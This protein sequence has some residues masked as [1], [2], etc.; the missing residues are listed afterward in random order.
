MTKRPD[1][2]TLTGNAKYRG[3]TLIGEYEGL[4]IFANVD[5]NGFSISVKPKSGPKR[6]RVYS[7]IISPYGFS[8]RFAQGKA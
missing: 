7:S 4:V 6:W 1:V 5:G 8:V 3:A 2:V